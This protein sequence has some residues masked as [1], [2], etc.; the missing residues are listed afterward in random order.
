M[1]LFDWAAPIF[2]RFA[3][4]WSEDHIADIAEKLAPY[5]G[6][7][8]AVLDLGGGTGALAVRIAEAFPA[9]VTVLDP[10]PK[11]VSYVPRHPAVSAVVGMAEAM[12]FDDGAF[13]VTVI[14]DA[15]HHFRD[16]DTAVR[17][18]AR[19]TRPGGALFMLEFDNRGAMRLV[20]WGEKLLGEPGSFFAPSELCTYL[21]ERGIG[22]T[23]VPTSKRSYYFLG[24]IR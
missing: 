3:D 15:F 12:P 20:V 18:I 14:S 8:R 19:V 2:H 5:L 1:S 24:E 16:Q 4:R 17:E 10:S 22:G 9:S 7:R 13:D 23:C 6:E 11:M 21:D